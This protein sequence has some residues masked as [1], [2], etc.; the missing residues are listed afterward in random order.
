M[1]NNIFWATIYNHS[2]RHDYI[3]L[4]HLGGEK[5]SA[6]LGLDEFR[7]K[8]QHTEFLRVL[9]DALAARPA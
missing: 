2:D 3:E 6:V 4:T 1:M 9:A 5:W 7:F 8:S